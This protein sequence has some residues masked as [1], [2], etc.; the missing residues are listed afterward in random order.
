VTG[1]LE[2][3]TV[4]DP[5]LFKDMES[6]EMPGRSVV[7]LASDPN[8]MRWT[9]KVCLTPELAE[10]YGFTDIDGTIHW[11][12]GDFMKQMRTAMSYPPSQWRPPKQPKAK[13]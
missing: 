4:K 5:T 12:A 3:G 10:E 8:V 9:G 2:K 6:P 1:N 7:A 13:L 11:G